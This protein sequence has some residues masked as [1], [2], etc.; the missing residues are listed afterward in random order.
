[1]AF[2]L[3]LVSFS[4]IPYTRYGLL[5]V[6]GWACSGVSFTRFLSFKLNL[7]R[8]SGDYTQLTII[9]GN[10]FRIDK[11][12]QRSVCLSEAGYHWLCMSG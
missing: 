10:D 4:E 6:G 2:Y 8:Y 12:L 11:D 9:P 3:D 7:Q 5:S 1:M